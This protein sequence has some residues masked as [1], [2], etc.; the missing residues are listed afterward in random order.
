MML[1]ITHVYFSVNLSADQKWF[2]LLSLVHEILTEYCFSLLVVSA[3]VAAAVKMVEDLNRFV[4]FLSQGICTA[5][6]L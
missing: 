4:G 3:A 6:L 1:V 2:S 5:F